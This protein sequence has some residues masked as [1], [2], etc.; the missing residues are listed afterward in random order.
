MHETLEY[1]EKSM[2]EKY[3]LNKNYVKDK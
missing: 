1:L 2:L 3:V